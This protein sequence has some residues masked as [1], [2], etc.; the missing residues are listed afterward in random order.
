MF[1]RPRA[2]NS[3]QQARNDR[4]RGQRRVARYQGICL[5]RQRARLRPIQRPVEHDGLVEQDRDPRGARVDLARELERDREVFERVV[6][7]PEAEPHQ[8]QPLA[9]G[10]L[11]LDVGLGQVLERV[12]IQ[13]LGFE[14]RM[15][16][17]RSAR[18]VEVQLGGFGAQT[19]LRRVERHR[20][21]P[22]QI[23]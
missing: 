22:R 21:Q 23:R 12:A 17:A 14:V 9:D 4:D 3:H 2:I 8:A 6:V 10:D 7:A 20:R 19:A 11:G 18:E 15:A 1:V 13:G 5:L 16:R